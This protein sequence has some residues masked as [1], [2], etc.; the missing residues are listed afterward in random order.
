MWELSK[1]F[2]FDAAHTL[3]REVE[4]E[5]SRRIHGHSYEAEVAVRGEANPSTGMLLDLA[6]LE[7]ALEEARA[8][9][10]HHFLDEIE[11][12]GPATLENLSRWI[13]SRVAPVVPGLERVTVRRD[14]SGDSCSYH[15]RVSQLEPAV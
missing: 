8:G 1:R 10:D 2:R 15:G 6:L 4:K 13:W 14:S 7:Q 5:S 9:L 11:D 3:Q 12:L